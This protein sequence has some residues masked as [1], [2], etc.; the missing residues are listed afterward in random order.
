[1]RAESFCP[2]AEM[3]NLRAEIWFVNG[4]ANPAERQNE[5]LVTVFVLQA[6]FALRGVTSEPGSL[7]HSSDTHINI[8]LFSLLSL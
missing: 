1:M 6:R 4:W 8:A 3:E 7:Q 5:R 2:H